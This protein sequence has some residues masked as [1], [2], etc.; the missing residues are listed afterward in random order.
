MLIIHL[1]GT[2]DVPSPL[3]LAIFDNLDGLLAGNMSILDLG[4]EEP[5][6]SYTLYDTLI[7]GFTKMGRNLQDTIPV[8]LG[9]IDDRCI[10]PS[11]IS[12][13]TRKV[14]RYIKKHCNEPEQLALPIQGLFTH[15]L[16]LSEDLIQEGV[17][18]E[19][20]LSGNLKRVKPLELN[21]CH[22]LNLRRILQQKQSGWKCAVSWIVDLLCLDQHPNEHTLRSQWNSIH[23]KYIKLV[24]SGR[25]S[26]E[27]LAEQYRPPTIPLQGPK[28]AE[29][30]MI[31]PPVPAVH[32]KVVGELTKA[33]EELALQSTLMHEIAMENAGLREQVLKFD[34]AKEE[35]KKKGT[36]I[37]QLKMKI[38]EM[39]PRNV[40][41]RLKR[42]DE[43]IEILNKDLAIKEGEVAKGQQHIAEVDGDL[44]KMEMNLDTIRKDKLKE[45]KSKHYWKKRSE[46][47]KQR[48]TIPENTCTNVKSHPEFKNMSQHLDNLENENLELQEFIQGLV[49][50][51]GAANL[52]VF[53]HG[54]YK[55]SIRIVYM[56]LL[57]MGV[58]IEH[59][60]DVVRTVLKNLLN[61]E[62]ER[63]PQKSLASVLAV[64]AQIVSQAHVA[65]AMLKNQNNTLHFDGTKK[66]FQEYAGFQV[67]TASGSFSM[68]HQLM[69]AGDTESYLEATEVTIQE[70]AESVSQ[71]GDEQ[72][73][74]QD[75]LFLSLKNIMT[76]RHIVNKCYAP[77]L[78]EVR[79]KHA[80]DVGLSEEQKHVNTLYCGLHILPNMATST[81]N[82][83]KIFEADQSVVRAAGFKTQNPIAY[84]LIYQV[85]K[86]FVLTS[87][88]QKS[89]DAL[90]FSD[91]LNEMN[92]PKCKIIT[93]LHNRFN[94]LF[95]DGGAVYYHRKHIY[96][97]LSSGRC[98]KNNRLLTTIR[99]TINNVHLLAECRALGIIGKL[100]AAPMWNLLENKSLGY[101]D[102]NPHWETLCS[103]VE[104]FSNNASDLLNGQSI[105]ESSTDVII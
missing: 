93:F 51:E 44:E 96:D 49:S 36:Q 7:D 19:R 2:M 59:C 69:A 74:I 41:R 40:N 83:M 21:N 68:G 47:M 71:D 22:I 91:Y 94:V 85:A 27:F 76:D 105:F 1:P 23:N 31:Q 102:M 12:N 89:G 5:V 100:I 88:C 6:I 17:T 34:Q 50:E 38:A 4:F 62:V 65:E 52:K 9:I 97:F 43:K 16:S 72:K 82:G 87:G 53:Q 46:I 55:D 92:V 101:F 103:Q 86:A 8:I 66:H 56:D 77:R 11:K 13:L 30:A 3:A 35:F 39:N 20:L 29:L 73:K 15:T 42:R 64:E 18:L 61:I 37:T 54:K 28:G 10:L 99:D 79:L 45:Q 67:S 90:D 81:I 57:G 75:E 33:Y 104:S 25:S 70:M 63:L 98:S 26:A 32:T 24:T 95:H 84:D 48:D 14:A 80:G 60:K 78:E 58:S